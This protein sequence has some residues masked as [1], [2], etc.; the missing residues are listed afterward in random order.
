MVKRCKRQDHDEW[1]WEAG[2][3]RGVILKKIGADFC[4]QE[5]HHATKNEPPY[6]IKNNKDKTGLVTNTKLQVLTQ[7][8]IQTGR[9]TKISSTKN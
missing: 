4:V 3:D 7:L 6:I 2:K 1:T 9:Q 8:I 5:M